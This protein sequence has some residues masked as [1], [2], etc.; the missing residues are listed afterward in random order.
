LN[1][2]A[3]T[4]HTFAASLGGPAVSQTFTLTNAGGSATADLTVTLNVAAGSHGFTTSGDTCTGTSL[5]PAQSDTSC[6]VTVT[7]APGKAGEPDTARLTPKGQ[8][9]AAAPLK[10]KP[11]VA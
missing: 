3:I 6:T 7:Y 9:G 4:S 1:G 5:G 11:S 10:R 2:A 8:K